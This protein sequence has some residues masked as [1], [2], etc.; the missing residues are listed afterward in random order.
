MSPGEALYAIFEAQ[1]LDDVKP[2][3]EWRQLPPAT[4]KRWEIVAHRFQESM[5]ERSNVPTQ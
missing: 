1:L 5:K 4:R 3:R 2:T